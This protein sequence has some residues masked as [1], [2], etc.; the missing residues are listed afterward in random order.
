MSALSEAESKSAIL[1]LANGRF[2]AQDRVIRCVRIHNVPGAKDS[3]WCVV[4]QN[5]VRRDQ[6]DISAVCPPPG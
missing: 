1:F 4:G 6:G 5:D 2:G 3:P